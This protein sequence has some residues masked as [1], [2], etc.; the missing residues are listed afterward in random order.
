MKKPSGLMFVEEKRSPTGVLSISKVNYAKLNYF[1][2]ETSPYLIS[3]SGQEPT[4]MI[5]HNGEFYVGDRDGTHKLSNR[6]T[7][8]G[9][10]NYV[11]SFA[12]FN[13]ELLASDA[14]DIYFPLKKGR[15][16]KFANLRDLR[17]DF[18]HSDPKTKYFDLVDTMVEHDGALHFGGYSAREQSG[19]FVMDHKGNV[20]RKPLGLF[21]SPVGSFVSMGDKLYLRHGHITGAFPDSSGQSH[22][23]SLKTGFK[24]S[25]DSQIWNMVGKDGKLL[26]SGDFSGVLVIDPVKGN[27]DTILQEFGTIGQMAVVPENFNFQKYTPRKK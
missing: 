22:V 19:V 16:K 18:D 1:D 5:H 4:A 13:K 21:G 3:I 8:A 17:M 11:Y 25:H 14:E 12:E 24:Y 7:V 9:T 26:C 23:S 15:G 2:G 10:K 20:N 6:K 27:V